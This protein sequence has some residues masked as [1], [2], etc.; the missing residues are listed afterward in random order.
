MDNETLLMLK[1]LEAELAEY[2][3][4]L[5]QVKEHILELKTLKAEI[6]ESNQNK[7]N[8]MMS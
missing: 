1:W 6:M 5:E 2:S 7:P 8:F 3:E 4:T